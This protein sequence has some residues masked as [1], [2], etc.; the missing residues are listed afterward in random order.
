MQNRIIHITKPDFFIVFYITFYFAFTPENVRGGF[1]RAGFIPLDLQK[2]IFQ[3]DIK[4]RTLTP[5][6]SPLLNADL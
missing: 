2:V 6:E 5:T 4:L 3:L 1:R